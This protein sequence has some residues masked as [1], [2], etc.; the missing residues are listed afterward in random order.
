MWD[1]EWGK[2]GQRCGNEEWEVT[3]DEVREGKMRWGVE[4]FPYKTEELSWSKSRISNLWGSLKFLHSSP[5]ATWWKMFSKGKSQRSLVINQAHEV[6][7]NK[8]ETET[9]RKAGQQLS[10]GQ[11]EKKKKEK[12]QKE[13][14]SRLT[15]SGEELWGR[16]V[17]LRKE[18]M[19]FKYTP[20]ANSFML[21]CTSQQ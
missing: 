3:L 16:V 4:M 1:K 21:L 17:S 19:N 12:R 2:A 13:K 6:E 7:Q 9:D 11:T 20:D 15:D 10:N 18:M 14:E 8:R 5:P